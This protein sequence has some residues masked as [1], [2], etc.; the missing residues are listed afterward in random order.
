MDVARISFPDF[1]FGCDSI[2]TG[3]PDTGT[4]SCDRQEKRLMK[5]ANRHLLEVAPEAIS[6]AS[7]K[8]ADLGSQCLRCT[9]VCRIDSALSCL[10]SVAVLVASV[11]WILTL[12]DMKQSLPAG[13][14][15]LNGLVI[16]WHA[17][18][19]TFSL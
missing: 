15:P 13:Q 2:D 19:S 16:K 12:V 3:N 17:R 9:G 11:V 14:D 7:D 1:L 4:T 8:M 18:H 6:I 10:P 5:L